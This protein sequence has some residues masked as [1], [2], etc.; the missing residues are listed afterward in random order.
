MTDEDIRTSEKNTSAPA[1]EPT[2]P[3]PRRRRG[4]Q[5]GNTN[6]LSH[7]FYSDQF[8]RDE[9]ARIA[10]YADDPTVDDEIW[11]QRVLNRRLLQYASR[12]DPDDAGTWIKIVEAM[13]VGTGRVARLLRARRDL[14][15]EPND[16]LARVINQSLDELS[17]ELGIA[18]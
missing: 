10:A 2:Q 4:G 17:D 7:G 6:R 13:A 18:L 3:R 11:M 14:S 5:P 8:S 16:A 15:G 12:I 9:L 1:A